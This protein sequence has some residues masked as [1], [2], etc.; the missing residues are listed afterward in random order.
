MPRLEFRVS[1]PLNLYYHLQLSCGTNPHLK[2]ESY[3]REFSPMVPK[4]ACWEFYFA[5]DRYW[6]TQRFF[7]EALGRAQ[8]LASLE[9]GFTRRFEGYVKAELLPELAEILKEAYSSYEPYWQKRYPELE[10]TREEIEA[11]WRE[12]EEEVFTKI[13]ELAKLDWKS[14]LYTVHLVDSLSYGGLV[15]GEGHYAIGACDCKTFLHILIH[16]LIHDNI[17]PALHRVH[18]ELEL[19]QAQEE[20]LDETFAKLIELEVT[21]AVTP[22]AEEPLEQKREEA[23]GEGFLEFFEAVLGDWPGYLEKIE[24]YLDIGAF[25]ME[26]ALKREQELELARPQL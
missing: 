9:E 7:I 5:Q 14:E 25:M 4:E 15:F 1:L 10:R 18:V 22:W 26:E 19:S 13:E 17:K 24:T 6:F 20:A 8:D 16:E 2:N 3:Q 21:K 12:C 23:R 11:R